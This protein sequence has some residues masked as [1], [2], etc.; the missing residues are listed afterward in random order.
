MSGCLLGCLDFS[1]LKR[2]MT[3]RDSDRKGIVK[4][5]TALPSPGHHDRGDDPARTQPPQDRPPT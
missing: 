5:L 1:V 2:H 3:H 4:L